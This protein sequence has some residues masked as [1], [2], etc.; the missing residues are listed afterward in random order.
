MSYLVTTYLE[1]LA[2]LTGAAAAAV[3]VDTYSTA[4]GL[5]T[6]A[7]VLLVG[8]FLIEAR[9]EQPQNEGERL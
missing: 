9:V 5:A 4:G 2:I 3:A 1:V 8:S 6:G 7:V